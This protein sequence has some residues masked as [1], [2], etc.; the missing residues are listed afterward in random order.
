MSVVILRAEILMPQARSLKEKR[1]PLNSLKER[2]R[3]R[4]GASVAEV[5]HHELHGR[6]ALEIAITARDAETAAELEEKA[7]R[8]IRSARDAEL[9]HLERQTVEPGLDLEAW[10]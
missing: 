6:S 2:L 5:D 4:L 8:M 3:R 1:S 9:L 10:Q 7:E